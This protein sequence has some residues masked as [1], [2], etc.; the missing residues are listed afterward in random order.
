[1]AIPSCPL[2]SHSKTAT[3]YVCYRAG[4]PTIYVIFC[5]KESHAAINHWKMGQ[6]ASWGLQNVLS[7][8]SFATNQSNLQ[9][10]SCCPQ[11]YSELCS[12]FHLY[13]VHNGCAFW[14]SRLI[15]DNPA[16]LL[17]FVES[18]SIRSPFGQ[19]SF[20]NPYISSAHSAVSVFT[21]QT[22]LY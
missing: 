19:L 2:G 16:T 18:L 17:H 14:C 5:S 9:G 15:C 13:P 1:M 3:T 6:V 22:P 20:L 21:C 8:W 4:I 11:N 12:G 10:A 7:L